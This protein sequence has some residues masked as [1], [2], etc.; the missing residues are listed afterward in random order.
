MP[1]ELS[2]QLREEAEAAQRDSMVVTS[3]SKIEQRIIEWLCQPVLGHI[4]RSVHPNTISLVNH[5]VSWVTAILAVGSV[6]LDQPY[7][8]LALAGAG[9]GMLLAMI[10]DCLDGMHARNTD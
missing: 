1:P 3:G 5:V 10:G 9:I 6:R 7:K 8:S 4:P 2:M